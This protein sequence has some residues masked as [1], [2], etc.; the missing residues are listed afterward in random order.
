MEITM[1]RPNSDNRRIDRLEQKVDEGFRQV[2]HRFE[3]VDQRFAQI[4]QRFEQVDK[5][6]EGVE[7]RME[8]GFRDLRSE[9]TFRLD[10]A[11][12]RF[13][14]FQRMMFIFYGGVIAALV[15]VI[16]QL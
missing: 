2:D 1:E 15:G 7:G 13:Y 14:A 4:D 16:A 12:E 9:I 5:R 6:L 11:D 8:N 10:R 3:Q